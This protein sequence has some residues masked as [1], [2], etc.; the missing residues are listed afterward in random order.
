MERMKWQTIGSR[1]SCQRLAKRG[2][3]EKEK[4]P[5]PADANQKAKRIGQRTRGK[6]GGLG[7]KNEMEKLIKIKSFRFDP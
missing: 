7:H 1:K 2:A 5:K 3:P 4:E 6:M